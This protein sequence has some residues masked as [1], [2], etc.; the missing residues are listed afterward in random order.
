MTTKHDTTMIAGD[1][2]IHDVMLTKEDGEEKSLV[3]AHIIYQVRKGYE[4][5]SIPIITK[6]NELNGGIIVTNAPLGL[7]EIRLEPADSAL[8]TGL[9][10]QE[11]EVT[12]GDGEV[13]TVFSGKINFGKKLIKR[14]VPAP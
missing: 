12:D 10:F 3:D 5:T 7:F 1:D 11:C 2:K 14:V 8:L 13:G 4:P 6:T 9:Y